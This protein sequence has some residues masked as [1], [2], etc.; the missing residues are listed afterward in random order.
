MNT[1]TT[2]AELKQLLQEKFIKEGRGTA[3]NPINLNDID[4]SNISNMNLLFAGR[5]QFNYIDISEWDISNVT[6][7][8]GMFAGCKLLMSVGNI[9]NW[10]IS[11]VE[12][13]K[14]MFKHCNVDIIPEWYNIHTHDKQQ[15][16]IE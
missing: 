10:D 2:W 6:T 7:M 1:P 8:Q 12:N 4:V 9:N 15:N 3:Q 16:Y 5:T 11:N 13:M 14:D